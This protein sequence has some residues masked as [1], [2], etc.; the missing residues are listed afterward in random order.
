[1][2]ARS[3]G[4]WR[5]TG[6]CALFACDV[7]SYGDARRTN[8]IQRH[9]RKNLY[10]LIEKSFD[11]GGIPYSAVYDED[12]GDGLIAAVP[13]EYEPAL[14][15]TGVTDWLRAGLWQYN[16]VSSEAAR[17]ELR[18][19]VHL[20]AAVHDGKGLVGVDVNHVCRILEESAFKALMKKRRA[21]I[22]VILSKRFHDDVVRTGMGLVVAE[23]YR[24]L[25]VSV[26]ETECEA[27]VRLLGGTEPEESAE[28]SRDVALRDSFPAVAR[29]GEFDAAPREGRWSAAGGTDPD[30][31]VELGA[32]DLFELVD[33]ALEISALFT[34]R[35]REQVLEA[36]PQ[37]I[38]V[39]VPRRHDARSDVYQIIKTCLDYPG[40]LHH[41][42]QAVR[43]FTGESLAVNRLERAV[44][45]M[46]RGE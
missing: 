3:E 8:G 10:E 15:I 42:L 41:F 32:A 40:G 24:P 39:V 31:Y 6:D 19:A 45:R 17:I 14:L 35:G 20:G 36:L 16:Q 11:N 28:P 38:A 25:G 27:W 7:V 43:V 21:P 13:R 34:E 5:P 1:M 29:S 22:G 46:L 2:L 12:R 44:A 4:R 26:K 23:D 30:E 33:R 37:T 9:I 18:V